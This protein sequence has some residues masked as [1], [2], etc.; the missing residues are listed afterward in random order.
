MI[1]T[2]GLTR[3]GGLTRRSFLLR[4]T[5]GL[6]GSAAFGWAG[7]VRAEA[8]AL[9]RRGMACILLFLQGGASQFETFDPKP[10]TDTG[11]PTK[12][13]DTVLPGVQIAEHWPKLAQQL[14]DI[15]LIRSVTSNEN[16]PQSRDLPGAHRLQDQC[17]RQVS[18]HRRGERHGARRRG[19]RSAGVRQHRAGQHRRTGLPGDDFRSP[20]R[21][22]CRA[23][24]PARRAARRTPRGR[25]EAAA[26][27]AR[28]SWN[29]TSPRARAGSSS[30]IT[31]R[32]T[33]RPP[34]SCR[35]PG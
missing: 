31:A 19:A 18:Q 28:A 10:G 15:A 6:L 3:D 17:Q 1:S 35:V 32:F 24:A 34:S 25:L 7:R 4:S 9:R 26:G 22:G 8:D 27:T 5:S 30:P 2:C 12:A 33:R 23:N 20:G 21:T 11:G 14:N 16:R 29:E 13:I